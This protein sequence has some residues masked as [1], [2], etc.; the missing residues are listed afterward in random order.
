M[1]G[2][3]REFRVGTLWVGTWGGNSWGAG[4]SLGLEM[5][6]PY[7]DI[8]GVGTRGGGKEFGVGILRLGILGALGS[9]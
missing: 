9:F 3:G 7:C 2:A 1:R 6:W 8:V 5:K 4:I